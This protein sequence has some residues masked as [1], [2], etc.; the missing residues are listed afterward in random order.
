MDRSGKVFV[1]LKLYNFFGRSVFVSPPNTDLP[2]RNFVRVQV[3]KRVL[4]LF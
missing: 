3:L 2:G 4:I 1:T